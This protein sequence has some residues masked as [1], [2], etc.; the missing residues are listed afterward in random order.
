MKRNTYRTGDM[1]WSRESR[2]AAYS[3]TVVIVGCILSL[4]IIAMVLI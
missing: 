1:G 2:R 3:A 4:L